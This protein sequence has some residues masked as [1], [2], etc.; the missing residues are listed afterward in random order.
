MCGYQCKLPRREVTDGI[1][2]LYCPLVFFFLFC[3]EEKSMR[4]IHT[5]INSGMETKSNNRKTVARVHISEIL[6]R[7]LSSVLKGFHSLY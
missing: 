1:A 7:I 3:F 6:N 4:L 2:I 5:M